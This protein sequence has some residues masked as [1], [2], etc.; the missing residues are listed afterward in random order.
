MPTLSNFTLH[1]DFFSGD[2]GLARGGPESDAYSYKTVSS[3]Q[4]TAAYLPLDYVRSRHLTPA[5][6]TFCYGIF[7]FE[8]VSGKSPSWMDPQTRDTIRDIMIDASQ[9]EPWID[10]SAGDCGSSSWPKCLFFLG[11]DCTK[12]RRK[13]RPLMQSVLRA[14]EQLHQNPSIR[15]IRSAYSDDQ[16]NVEGRKD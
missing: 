7:L 2:F 9:P 15:S 10:S 8:L 13:N 6:D 4:G 3:V 11:R 14:V 16:R 1:F 5:V 12:S